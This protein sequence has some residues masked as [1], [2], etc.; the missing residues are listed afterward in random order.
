MNEGG[1]IIYYSNNNNNRW[2][3]PNRVASI[4][5]SLDSTVFLFVEQSPPKL[6]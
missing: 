4:D 6:L 5:S 3:P 1:Y 2:V